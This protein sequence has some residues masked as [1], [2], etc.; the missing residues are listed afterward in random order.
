MMTLWETVNVTFV[1]LCWCCIE[2][3]WCL[4]TNKLKFSL[5]WQ[6]RIVFACFWRWQMFSVLNDE[7]HRLSRVVE[8]FDRPF[9]A[10]PTTLKLYKKVYMHFI[11]E[12]D[13]CNW[14]KNTVK[15]WAQETI[16]CV[17]SRSALSACDCVVC[18][19]CSHV[20]KYSTEAVPRI[21]KQ[22]C[23]RLFCQSLQ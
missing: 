1:S 22:F 9:D 17:S 6:I 20:V 2:I 16:L 18:N 4:V 21:V 19:A 15:Y 11:S 8:E 12:I 7:I 23:C 13:C 5:W 10:D 3:V 14:R